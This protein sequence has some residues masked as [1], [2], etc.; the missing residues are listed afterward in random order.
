MASPCFHCGQAIPIGDLVLR[1]IK[2]VEQEFCCH[3]C[4]GVCEVIHEAGLQSFYR[5][6]PEGELLSPPPPPNKDAIFYDHDE[7]QSQF[8]KNLTQIREIVLM[9]DAIH[10]PACIWL[11]ERSLARFEGILLAKVNF[12]NKRIKLRWDNNKIKLSQIIHE[13]NRVGYDATPYDSTA[14]EEAYRK[15][16]R[17]LLYRLGYAGFAMMNV[18]WFSVALYFGADE[19]PVFRQYFHW[20]GFLLA[21]TVI[22]YSAKPFFTGAWASFK[23]KTVGMDTSIALGILTTYFYSVWVTLDVNHSGEVYFDTMVDFVFL[24][25][26]GRYLEIIYRNKAVDSSRRLMGLQAK[27]ARQIVTGEGEKIVPVRTLLQGDRV[28]VKPGEKFPVDGS[29]V[30]GQSSVNEAMLTGESREV[31][32]KQGSNVSAGT[33]NLDGAVQVEVTAIMQDTML[34]KIVAMVEDAQGS[35]SPIQC[36]TDKIMPW[37]VAIVLVLAALSFTFWIFNADLEKAIIVATAVLIITCPCALGLATPMATAVASGLSAQ[38]GI[39]IK[40]GAVLEILNNVTHF[41]FDKTGTLTK[42]KMEVKSIQITASQDKMHVLQQIASIEEHSEHSLAQS[43]TLHILEEYPEFKN[44]LLDISDFKSYSGKG[45]TASVGGKNFHIGTAVWL[46]S[47]GI[48]MPKS[49]VNSADEAGKMGQ[50]SVWVAKDN[51]IVSMILL[52]DELRA[53]ALELITRLKAQNKTVILLTGDRKLVANSVAEQL[54]GMEVIAEVL[55]S[56]KNA[57]IRKLQQDGSLVAMI[58]DGVNDAPA[59]V[60]S[61]VGIALGSGTDV[62]TESADVVLLSNELLAV[63]TIV[64]LSARTI[65]TIKQNMSISLA[66]NIMFVPLAMVGLLTPI[67]AAI[68]MPISSLIVIGNAVRIR[69]FFKPKKIAQRNT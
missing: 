45:V 9:S 20:L 34:G 10:C 14:S 40:N 25:L 55:P 30:K 62:S 33:L 18:M 2:D 29:I 52:E 11:I 36:M 13:L 16:N 8:V 54:G 31:F 23:A 1:P 63:D 19:D 60:R 68:T 51:K 56:D 48:K 32:K 46:E 35:K 37:F 61:D 49:W 38:N 59:L 43:I 28:F 53:N 42:G 47:T 24:L 17:K 6:T 65:K 50:T 21:T 57:V 26:I 27:V 5:R 3:G 58:G 67:I 12:T 15:A 22:V 44:N 64:G 7:V 66:Y 41:V 69:T 39:L 4:A